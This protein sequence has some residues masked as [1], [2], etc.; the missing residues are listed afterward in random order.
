MRLQ[1]YITTFAVLG[2]TVLFSATVI[3]QDPD[4]DML[5]GPSIQDEEVTQEDMRAE[6]ARTT[7]KS[8]LNHQNKEQLRVW[9]RTLRSL[10]LTEDQQTEVNSMVQ[11]YYKVQEAF[12]KEFLTNA[13]LAYD[14]N[15]SETAKSLKIDRTNLYKKIQKLNIKINKSM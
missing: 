13:L 7:G 14:W 1:N 9:L 2:S 11:K 15:V 12:Q 10:D 6:H 8:K 3:A 5:A 4:G